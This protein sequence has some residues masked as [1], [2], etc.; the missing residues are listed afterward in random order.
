MLCALAG[1][2]LAVMLLGARTLPAQRSEADS[3]SVWLERRAVR[4]ALPS[5]VIPERTWPV[6]GERSRRS[7]SD[8]NVRVDHA[9]IGAAVGGLAGFF[10][11]PIIYCNSFDHRDVCVLAAPDGIWMGSFVGSALGGSF[12]RGSCGAFHSFPWATIGSAIGSLPGLAIRL[13]G[14]DVGTLLMPVGQ[15]LGGAFLASRCR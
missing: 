6:D 10:A 2:L 13:H 8:F 9:L 4:Y 5:M 12:G 1:A 14:N 15:A 7:S 11:A 3:E